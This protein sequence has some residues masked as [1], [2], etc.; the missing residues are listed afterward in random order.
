MSNSFVPTRQAGSVC[1]K[2]VG[3][4]YQKRKEAVVIAERNK[5]AASAIVAAA[6]IHKIQIVRKLLIEGPNTG[7]KPS[8]EAASA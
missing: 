7:I 5:Y 1:S 2:E 6:E 3:P 4:Q 8:R